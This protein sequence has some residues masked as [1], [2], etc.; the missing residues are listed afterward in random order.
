MSAPAAMAARASARFVMPQIFILINDMV[1]Q[2][3]CLRP[4]RRSFSLAQAFTPGCP[5]TQISIQPP[6]GG[7]TKFRLQANHHLHTRIFPIP[8]TSCLAGGAPP[9]GQY[10]GKP[11]RSHPCAESTLIRHRVVANGPASAGL[12]FFVHDLQQVWS[13]NAIN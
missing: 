1:L 3:R 5:H 11:S 8:E 10:T 7:F 6:S 2:L 4:R 12:H 9:D 13:P